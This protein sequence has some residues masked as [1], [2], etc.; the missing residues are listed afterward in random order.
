MLLPQVLLSF[1]TAQTYVLWSK[2]VPLPKVMEWMWIE[3]KEK[4]PTATTV[5]EGMEFK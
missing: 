3:P 2:Y 1:A 5:T 4:D